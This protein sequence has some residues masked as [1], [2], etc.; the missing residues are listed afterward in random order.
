MWKLYPRRRTLAVVICKPSKTR[1]DSGIVR[2]SVG[3]GTSMNDAKRAAE[4]LGK[5][6]KALQSRPKEACALKP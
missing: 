3:V 4:I 2:L 6:V 1:F 5:A